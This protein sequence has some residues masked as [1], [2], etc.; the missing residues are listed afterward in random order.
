VN[1]NARPTLGDDPYRIG[2]AVAV[3]S[4]TNPEVE[5]IGGGSNAYNP[6]DFMHYLYREYTGDF[7]VVVAV[8][9]FDRRGIAG[10]YGNGGIHVRA[11]LYRTDNNEIADKTKVPSYV[12]ITYYE[13]SDADRAAIELNRPE[14]GANYGNNTPNGNNTEVG[15]RLGFFTGL[16]AIN[17]AGELSPNYSPT[18]AKWL[19]VKRVG[20]SFSSLLSY[21][22]VN[23]FEQDQGN[24]PMP[25]L[26]ATVLVGFGHHND[27]GYGVPPEGNTYAGN[28]T[29]TQNESNY[30][31]VRIS[32]LGNFATINEPGPGPAVS[33]EIRKTAQ[34]VVI[35]WTGSGYTLLSAPS[36]AGPYTASTLPVVSVGDRN[37]VTINANAAQSFYQLRR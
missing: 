26:P 1:P 23:W 28:G 10:G 2:R 34:G 14:A 36:V 13:G 32:A 11:G 31:V 37:T 19:R 20:Q 15:G 21:D 16:G 3:S 6:G 5:I 30:G 27:T 8:N 33:L 17:A 9:R 22:G 18:Q 29:K 25:N 7:D 35:S 4:T 12:N 24:K